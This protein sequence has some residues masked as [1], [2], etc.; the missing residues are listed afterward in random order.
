MK[1]ESERPKP[2]EQTEEKKSMKTSQLNQYK[3]RAQN[4]TSKAELEVRRL[5]AVIGKMW[6]EWN[7]PW[8]TRSIRQQYYEAHHWMRLYWLGED[9]GYSLKTGLQTRTF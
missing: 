1:R 2:R 6:V 3:E 7:G 4:R 5:E 9:M 8:E